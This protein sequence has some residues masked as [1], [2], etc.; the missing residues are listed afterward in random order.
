MPPTFRCRCTPIRSNQRRNWRRRGRRRG[1]RPP[2]VARN[3]QRPADDALLRPVDV[4]VPEQRDE[5]VGDRAAHGVLEIEDAGIAP[6][7]DHEVARVVVA[8]HEHLRLLERIRDQQR[9]MPRRA[10][11]ASA[12]AARARG[13]APTASRG[14]GSSR[15]AAASRRRAAACRECASA[16][17][18]DAHQRIDRVRVQRLRP[19]LRSASSGEVHDASRGP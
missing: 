9:R 14:R 18:L 15:S 17:R 12:S 1:R 8:V 3:S 10:C 16:A 7:A 5:V 13:A 2:P 11:A 19:A 4:A 6:R